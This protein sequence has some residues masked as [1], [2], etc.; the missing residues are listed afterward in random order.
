VP[1][2]LKAQLG[3][4]GRLVIP[5][6]TQERHQEL[7]KTTRTGESEYEQ[8]NLGA[9][10]FVPLIGE[11]GWAEDGH[12]AASN[13]VPSAAR[14]E[15]V[16]RMIAAAAELLPDIDDPAFGELFDRF[17]D[18]ASFFWAKQVT[19]L[20]NSIAHAPPSRAA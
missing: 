18:G 20:P 12:R 2:A 10:M 19:V 16:E 6:G 8:A 13:H 14:G 9:V 15:T 7:L 1:H 17:A 3:I 11:Q 4:G 5:V